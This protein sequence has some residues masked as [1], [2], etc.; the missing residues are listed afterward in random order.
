MFFYRDGYGW[1][2]PKELYNFR[3]EQPIIGYRQ[4]YSHPRYFRIGGYGSD[5]GAALGHGSIGYGNRGFGYNS[6][7]GYGSSAFS[8]SYQGG[9][10]LGGYGGY[11][12]NLNSYGSGFGGG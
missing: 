2:Q 3:Y 4:R 6:G 10:G 11:G 8:Q 9:G 7:L 1:K 12:G 5:H